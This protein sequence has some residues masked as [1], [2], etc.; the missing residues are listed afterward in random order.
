MLT[1]NGDEDLAR[2]LLRAG[3]FDYVRKPFELDLLEGVVA[4]AVAVG[5]RF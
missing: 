1:G 3:A 4:A 5:R 2:R